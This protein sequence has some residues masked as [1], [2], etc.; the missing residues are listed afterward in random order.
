[1][2]ERR[3][4][5]APM[6][7]RAFRTLWIATLVSNLGSLVQMVGAGWMMTSLSGSDDLVALVQASN[8]L[9]I[10]VLALVAGAMADSYPRRTVMLTAQSFMCVVS[11]L[12]AVAAYQGLLSPWALLTFT[13]LI[14]CGQAMHLPAWQSSMRDLVPRE[15][16]QS[17]VTLNSM[18]FNA[19]RSVGPALGGLIVASA[20]PAAAFTL[21]ALSY[22]AVIAALILWRP[23]REDQGLPREGLASAMAAGVRYVA[24]S[25]NLMAILARAL[26]YGFTVVSVLALMPLIARDLLGGTAITFGLCLGAFGLGGIGGALA[27]PRLRERFETEAIVTGAFLTFAAGTAVV[28][29][30][31]TLPLTLLALVPTGAAWVQA[32]SLFNVSVQLATPRWVVGRAVSL[33]QT[34][35]FG[36]MAAGSW[37]WGTISDAAGP[38]TALLI[39]AGAMLPGAAMGRLRP[40]PGFSSL[41]LD[42]LNR[43]SEPA[44]RLDLKGRSGPIM[45]MIDWTIPAEKTESFLAVM[46]DRRRIRLRDGARQWALMRDLE[47]PETWTEAYHVPT[48]TEYIRHNQRRTKADADNFD[49]LLELNGGRRP[50]VHRMIERQTVP[51]HDDMPILQNPKVL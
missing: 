17:A 45:V 1:M 30:S 47:N 21:N 37:A 2:P 40:V 16:L 39:A 5:F 22:L 42:P 24:M 13:F 35:T 46:A 33:Y 8:T 51:T 36:A 28:A 34:V 6:R 4:A 7:V 48:W 44:L 50:H 49:R 25:P 20:G 41:D 18:S 27:S 29:F 12:L 9:P 32:L 19:M 38:E 31:R 15:D 3:S 26:A 14:G 11:A 43:F 23:E 10:M